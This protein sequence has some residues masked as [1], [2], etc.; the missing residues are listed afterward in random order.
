MPTK[1]G[2]NIKCDVNSKSAFCKAA[3]VVR[4]VGIISKEV[5][6]TTITRMGFDGKPFTF[7]AN[8]GDKVYRN[9]MIKTAPDGSVAIT[10][11]DKT[12]ISG[13]ASNTIDLQKFEVPDAASGTDGIKRGSLSM[14]SGKIAPATDHPVSFQSPGAA[15]GVRG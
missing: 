8:A 11:N 9:D 4:P 2:Q 15:G 1:D 3:E 10:M 7:E 13:G 5:G 12:I 14:M 6:M